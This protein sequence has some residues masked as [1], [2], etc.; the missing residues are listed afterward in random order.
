M[1]E[2]DSISAEEAAENLQN[3]RPIDRETTVLLVDNLK[4]N[5]LSKRMWEDQMQLVGSGYQTFLNASSGRERGGEASQVGGECGE[6][7]EV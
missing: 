7:Y 6:L 3:M 5:L 2:N 4:K 1:L